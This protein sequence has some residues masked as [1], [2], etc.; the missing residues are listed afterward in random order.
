MHVRT[1]IRERVTSWMT[2]YVTAYTRLSTLELVY[3]SSNVAVRQLDGQTDRKR[4]FRAYL[5]NPIS[6][7]TNKQVRHELGRGGE[8]ETRRA[9]FEFRCDM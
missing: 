6:G 4:N 3:V 8:L 5:R 1:S 7:A 2:T 9:I